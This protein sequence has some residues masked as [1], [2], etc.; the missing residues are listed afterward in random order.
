MKL[1]P[2]GRRVCVIT[3]TSI[4]LLLGGAALSA[5]DVPVTTSGIVSVTNS[6]PPIYNGQYV[7]QTTDFGF[8]WLDTVALRSGLVQAESSCAPGMPNSSTNLYVIGDCNGTGNISSSGNVVLVRQ[9]GPNCGTVTKGCDGPVKAGPF[10]LTFSLGTWAYL[11]DLGNIPNSTQT[12]DPQGRTWI[13]QPTDTTGRNFNWHASGNPNAPPTANATATNLSAAGRID[14]T[15]YYGDKWQL[16]DASVS[17][18]ALTRID[19]DFLYKSSFAPDEVGTPANEGTVVGYFPC[20][21]SGGTQGSFRTGANCMQSLGL[22]NPPA[23]NSYR[24]AMQSANQN[25]TSVSPFLSSAVQFVCPQATILGYTGFTGTCAKTGGTLNVLLGGNA[26]ASGSTGNLLEATFN[27]SFTGSNPIS[28]QGAVVPVPSGATGFTLTITY[29][30]GYRATAQGS[31][32]Q[33]SLV[34]AFSLAP[35][36]V[37]I[38]TPLTLTNQMQKVAATLNSVDSL[39]KPGVCG[40]PPPVPTNPLGSGFVAGGSTTVTAPSTTGSYCISL[41]YSYTP[42]GQLQQSQIVSKGFTAMDWM[43]V[44]Q[45]SISPVPFCTGSCQIQAGT[46]YSLWDSENIPVSP[47]PGAQWDL[48]GTPIGAVTDANA[49]ISWTPTSACSSCTIRVTINGSIATLPVVV[50]G[51]VVPT[52][53]PTPTPSPSPTPTPTSGPVA[54]TVQVP[55]T[56]SVNV[57]LTFTANATG[58]TGSFTYAWACNYDAVSQV[59]T[60]GGQTVS[61]TYTAGGTY[62][63]K[64]KVTDAASAT[65]Y[66]AG[67]TVTIG[68]VCGSFT[69]ISDSTFCPFI[70]GIANAGITTGCAPG[71]Y[72]PNDSVSRLQMAI[73]IARAEA[74]GDASVPSS[75]TAQGQPYNCAS[76]GTS[77]FSDISPADPFCR[78]VHYIY[79]AGVTTGCSP[80]KYCPELGVT[81]GQMAL[82]IARAVA[83]GDAAVPQTYGPDAATGR[84]YSCNVAIPNLHFTDITTGDM[85]CRHTHYLWAKD[86]ISGFPDNSYGP[87]LDVSR[88]SMAKVLA[89]GFKLPM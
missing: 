63:V 42:Q 88:A 51:P 33:A 43:A 6:L 15:D 9:F 57:P 47:H 32:V 56:G 78:H 64:A 27:W 8:L 29:P 36:P 75:G 40:T 28:V 35:D 52:P 84:S 30:G 74:G 73:F 13:V 76:G 81:R 69:D 10:R 87:A 44:P 59:F 20:D 61:C 5:Q 60:A 83:G 26:D 71:N 45:I 80:G 86:V 49:S 19:W 21:P 12:A 17:A 54:V 25:G 46:T 1:N 2:S 18:L 65:G 31:I 72:C 22:T 89:N 48:S 34:A 55:A 53:S 16:Q 11:G 23:S 14:K 50:S 38:N 79:A 67:T 62:T 37:L 58:G 3:L 39:I 70:L 7:L 66:S 77:L 24:F 4:S 85:Y 41:K 82:F 68:V